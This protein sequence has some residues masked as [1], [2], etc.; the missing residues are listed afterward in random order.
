MAVT[1][2][3][4]TI[5]SSALALSALL[6]G[7]SAI[8]APAARARDKKADDLRARVEHAEQLAG[9]TPLEG[10]GLVI[11][12]RN[13]PRPAPRGVDRRKLQLREVD[14]NGVLSALRTAG[15][16]ALAVSG[17]NTQKPQR[18]VATS[19]AREGAGGIL[20]NGELLQPPYQIHAIGDAE[21]LRG[22]LLRPDGVVRRACLEMLQMIAISEPQTISV[23]AVEAE[24][25]FRFAHAPGV[26]P[27]PVAQENKT[28]ESDVRTVAEDKP[29]ASSKSLF[30]GKGLSRY[31]RPGCRF[32]ERIDAASRVTF[33]SVED[34]QRAGRTPCPVCHPER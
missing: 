29:A 9:L 25:E 2:T 3:K 11:T 14:L 19:A 30:G 5:Q 20:I 22:E 1:N 32:G 16:E 8:L 15:A 7:C 4:R 28:T 21:A 31:H 23:P 34:A 33:K 13:S 10:P 24:P 18:I 17:A 27:K 6:L 26:A 12:L